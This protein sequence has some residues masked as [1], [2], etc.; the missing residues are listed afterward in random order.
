MSDNGKLDELLSN[1][2]KKLLPLKLCPSSKSTK[3]DIANAIQ[4]A[5]RQSKIPSFFAA[6]PTTKA[7]TS[8]ASTDLSGSPAKKKSKPT[9]CMNKVV[10]SVI[11]GN[12]KSDATTKSSTAILSSV[13]VDERKLAVKPV[14]LWLVQS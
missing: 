8:T 2:A 9:D 3:S 14:V 5:R 1:L 4:K 13:G 6:V 10:A 12:A 11:S 7:S